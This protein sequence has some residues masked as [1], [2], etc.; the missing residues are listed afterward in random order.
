MDS[1]EITEPGGKSFL[2]DSTEKSGWDGSGLWPQQYA[3]KDWRSAALKRDAD[4]ITGRQI[5]SFN[6][7][8]TPQRDTGDSAITN[9]HRV[10]MSHWSNPASAPSGKNDLGN[11]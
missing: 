8:N 11:F 1:T 3:T 5:N 9:I 6:I 10:N 2:M 7:L 4:Q